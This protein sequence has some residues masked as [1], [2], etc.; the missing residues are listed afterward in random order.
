MAANSALVSGQGR[1]AFESTGFPAVSSGEA[2]QQG[3]GRTGKARFSPKCHIS[4][5]L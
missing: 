2:R 1:D 3:G 4:L 5:T